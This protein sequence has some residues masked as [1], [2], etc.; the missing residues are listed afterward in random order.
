[1]TAGPLRSRI[2]FDKR[3]DLSA[4]SPPGDGH[5]NEEGDWEEQ[6]VRNARLRPKLGGEQVMA[7][8]LQ[9]IQPY[10]ITVR[11]DSETRLIQTSWRAR[12]EADGIIYAILGITNPDEKRKYIEL[13][14]QAGAVA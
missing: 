5:G 11:F 2:A 4:N 12:N 14:V 6:F 9:G 13:T 10:T 8:R 3:E 1:M 7:S